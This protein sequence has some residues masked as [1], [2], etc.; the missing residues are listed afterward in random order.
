MRLLKRSCPAVSHSCNLTWGSERE[1][2]GD[3]S[4]S[5]GAWKEE[6]PSRHTHTHI[7]INMYVRISISHSHTHYLQK[8]TRH[9]D[10]SNVVLLH[11]RLRLMDMQTVWLCSPKYQ[12]LQGADRLFMRFSACIITGTCFCLTGVT[13]PLHL[14]TFNIFVRTSRKWGFLP[15][16]PPSTWF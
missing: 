14:W 13:A 12:E 4:D 3:Y 9:D 11:E 8:Q 6:A 1:S 2:W 15:F 5:Q 7:F 10:T 16:D